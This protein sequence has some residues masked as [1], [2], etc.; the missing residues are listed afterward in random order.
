MQ[1]SRTTLAV[2]VALALSGAGLA[3]LASAQCAP[4]A[5]N[6][7]DTNVSS[8]VKYRARSETGVANANGTLQPATASLDTPQHEYRFDLGYDSR[9]RLVA[10]KSVST[11]APDADAAQAGT[12]QRIRALHTLESQLVT[13]DDGC[14]YLG[15][16]PDNRASGSPLDGL[17]TTGSLAQGMIARTTADLARRGKVTTLAANRMRVESSAPASVT[18]GNLAAEDACDYVLRNGVWVMESCT[19]T[20]T[21]YT[22]VNGRV[23]YFKN[24]STHDFAVLS[25]SVNEANEQRRGRAAPNPRTRSAIGTITSLVTAAVAQPRATASRA[26]PAQNV[27]SIPGGQNVVFQHGIFSSGKTWERMD[28]WLA[29]QFAFGN[30]L[31]PDLPSVARITAQRDQLATLLDQSGGKDY[32]LIGHS[33]GGLVSRS[34]AQARPDLV[35]G[36]ITNSTLHNG[37]ILAQAVRDEAARGIRAAASHLGLGCRTPFDAISCFLTWVVQDPFVSSAIASYAFDAAIPVTQ[38]MR[39]A[40]PFIAQLNSAAESFPRVS[41]ENKSDPRWVAFRVL[42]DNF[43]NPDS[44]CGGRAWA[45]YVNAVYIALRT[46]VPVALSL[47]YFDIQ[48][49]LFYRNIARQC[50]HAAGALDAVDNYW[51]KLYS[52]NTGGDGIVNIDGQRWNG[53]QAVRIASADSHQ[54]VN[55]SDKVRDA[56]VR[57]LDQQFQVPRRA[58]GSPVSLSAASYS[59]GTLAPDSIVSMFGTGLATSTDIASSVPLPTT[60]GGASIDV[61][62]AAGVTRPASLFFA[63][64]T[65]INYALPA[66]LASGPAT[67]I[68]RTAR[69]V[70]TGTLTVAPVAPGVFTADASGAGPA[71]AYFTRDRGGVQTNEPVA[72]HDPSSNTMKTV[73]VDIATPGDQV[74]L[75]LFA[76]G[77]RARTSLDNVIV[78]IGGVAHRAVFAG[79]QGMVGLDQINIL[80]SRELIGRGEIDV[81]LTVDGQ[82]AN[83]TRIAVR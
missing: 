75:I 25:Q 28:G 1:Q 18:S 2:A 64:P 63:A 6:P 33:N 8:N 5:I 57:V 7:A 45:S 44:G 52:N 62:D 41:I 42:G 65:Q 10:R 16:S 34:L 58:P 11:A 4:P 24:T 39:P 83:K 26:S 21:S 43:C 23:E 67:V 68:V 51:N 38:D 53:A 59:G 55:K 72:A 20:T 71:A 13:D 37:A 61:T 35:R 70:K 80:L 73:P 22:L 40:S 19:L 50:S 17:P 54:G 69:E 77:L 66:G 76:T 46:C 48:N 78:Q 31:R 9:Q 27:A 30:D 3:G 79:A 74:Y 15:A 81:V 29:P 82:A 60:L 56:L 49:F 14:K 32:I 36:V 47:G 12:Y